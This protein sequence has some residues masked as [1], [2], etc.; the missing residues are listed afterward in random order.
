M[1]NKTK[2]YLSLTLSDN[3]KQGQ[4]SSTRVEYV[5]YHIAYRLHIHKDNDFLTIYG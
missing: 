2:I 4:N 1:F 5:I 3:G